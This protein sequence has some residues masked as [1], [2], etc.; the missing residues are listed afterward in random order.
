MSNLTP[1]DRV[2]HPKQQGWGLG[3]VLTVTADSIDVFFVG[4][5]AKRLAK[6]YVQLEVAEG[7]TAKH[8]LLDNLVDASQIAG[9]DYVTP[10]M[11]SERFLAAYP[12]G[13]A[14]PRLAKEVREAVMRAHQFAIQLLGQ[15]EIAELIAERR[16]QDVCDRARHVE[17][18][19]T[20]LTKTEKTALYAALDQPLQ[21][22]TFALA[23][24]DL[25][26]GTES[27]ENRFKEFARSLHLLDINRWPYATLFSFIRFPQEKLFI[28][29]TLIQNVAKA[30]C[31]RI[32]YKAEP[33]WRT[34][35]AVL[36][37]YYHLGNSLGEQ[38][39]APQDMI[40]VQAFVVSVAQK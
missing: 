33:N 23:L 27:E 18:L 15:T 11:A 2:F 30:F 36:R 6:S 38:G 12:D 31:W 26:Y 39:M 4:S 22:K 10:A 9:A 25:L 3:K 17:S 28:K 40:D 20:L 1:G 34:Y 5:G 7:A 32:N 24:A 37:L 35:A 29:P 21:Q 19:T 16:Y 14:A 13:F 8:R